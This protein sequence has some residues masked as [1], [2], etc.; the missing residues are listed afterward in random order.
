MAKYHRLYMASAA[1]AFALTLNGAANAS[2]GGT[3]Y[4]MS[5]GSVAPAPVGFLRF[6]G[7]SPAACGGAAGDFQAQ[8]ALANEGAITE[9]GD[10]VE[11]AFGGAPRLSVS[12][13]SLSSPVRFSLRSLER[14]LRAE[15][16]DAVHTAA[17][18]PGAMLRRLR[19]E[20]AQT[21]ARQPPAR[22]IVPMAEGAAAAPARIFMDKA[23]AKLLNTVNRRVNRAVSPRSD[24]EVVGRSEYWSL[25]MARGDRLYGDCE[26]YALQKKAD[27]VA[28][29]LPMAAMTMAVAR[30]HEG[31]V[32][33]VLIVATNRGDL[34]L[35]NRST[36][37]LPWTSVK[38]RW[39]MRQ[40]SGDSLQWAQVEVDLKA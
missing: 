18:P 13:Q 5:L 4:F 32:H 15:D 1:L 7:S 11:V 25:P 2:V 20:D 33:A 36:R 22:E 30:T 23:T 29:G 8:E 27:L 31:L 35:D 24:L 38:Y 28:A 40:V 16:A 39:V 26:D 19:I 14:D 37:V 6:C 3:P 21:D 10:K 12:L 9:G 17:G 34:V